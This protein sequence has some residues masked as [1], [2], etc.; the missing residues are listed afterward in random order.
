[1]RAQS[2]KAL[3]TVLSGAVARASGARLLVSAKVEKRGQDGFGHGLK[4]Q[5]KQGFVMDFMY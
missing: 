5:F 3:L 4:R 2:C 1:M